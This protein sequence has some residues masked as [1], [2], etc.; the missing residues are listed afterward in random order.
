MS[1]DPDTKKW[2][3][4][5]GVA[6]AIAIAAGLLVGYFT[7]FILGIFTIFTISGLYLSIAFY[8]R[9]KKDISGGPSEFGAVVMGG[10]LVAGIGVCGFIYMFTENVVLTIACVLGVVMLSTAVMI[11][12][13][14]KYL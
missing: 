4:A 1:D 6:F 10:V 5:S 14:K 11:I 12:S 13:Y 8:I 2:N 3:T 7:E 9:G